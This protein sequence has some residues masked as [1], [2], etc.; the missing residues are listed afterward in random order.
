VEVG[1]EGILQMAGKHVRK[2]RKKIMDTTLSI[3]TLQVTLKTL[4]MEFSHDVSHVP[5]K[6][7]HFSVHV[8]SPGKDGATVLHLHATPHASGAIL[9]F[10]VDKEELQAGDVVIVS[11]SHAIG[12]KDLENL[13]EH[14]EVE[15]ISRQP[16]SAQVLEGDAPAEEIPGDNE[17][18]T[19]AAY[20]YCAEPEKVAMEQVHKAVEIFIEKSRHSK[21]AESL[22]HCVE[23]VAKAEDCTDSRCLSVQ[24]LIHCV[25]EAQE[26]LGENSTPEFEAV[27]RAV[28]RLNQIWCKQDQ[29]QTSL[30][31]M[32]NCLHS[33][34]ERF[35][36]CF[37]KY[38]KRSPASGLDILRII[39]EQFAMTARMVREFET[40]AGIESI[41]RLREQL[42]HSQ[43]ALE[44]ACCSL[45]CYWNTQQLMWC[46]VDR[47]Q[48]LQALIGA[49]VQFVARVRV[50]LQNMTINPAAPATQ[51]A[52]KFTAISDLTAQIAKQI[53]ALKT[54][55]EASRLSTVTALLGKI[56][57]LVPSMSANAAA[58]QTITSA[59]CAQVAKYRAFAAQIE[60][61]VDQLV[62]MKELDRCCIKDSLLKISW[63]V[64]QIFCFLTHVEKDCQRLKREQKLPP[65]P[66][67][68]PLPP[69][70]EVVNNLLPEQTGHVFEISAPLAEEL[71]SAPD[72]NAIFKVLNATT[73]EAAAVIPAT[74]QQI[75]QVR[76]DAG[77]ALEFQAI[78]GGVLKG[79]TFALV[80]APPTN[81]SIISA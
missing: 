76:A 30:W 48:E 72:G 60:Q 81:G 63:V 56:Q 61:H 50:L 51:F 36:K 38:G 62:C 6:G 52:A 80:A 26:E 34:R 66:T 75:V 18:A 9:R 24:K 64:V 49:G 16:V 20:D 5:F 47:A 8:F 74:G 37:E 53:S 59:S 58:F 14:A 2:R 44:E 68:L 54:P 43:S 46:T 42:L 4:Q 13:R 57:A 33:A 65:H 41:L 17:V 35:K 45:T 12:E 23:A 55:L 7:K 39:D 22:K 73:G 77:V 70:I 29:V 69:L 1:Y 19:F 15:D 27:R 25:A 28:W 40:C 10:D 3:K 32:M 78:K 21:A 79:S 67:P 31:Q 11:I 71:A